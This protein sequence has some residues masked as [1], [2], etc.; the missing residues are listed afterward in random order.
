MPT[1]LLTC[2]EF[3]PNPVL[4]HPRTAPRICS[5]D[6]YQLPEVDLCRFSGMLIP[7][8][9]DQRFLLSAMEF[10]EVFLGHG[11]SLGICGHMAHPFLP[12]LSPFVP[13]EVASHRDYAV[14]RVEE[15]PVF[16]GVD[17]MDLTFRKGVAGFYGRG[18]NPPPPGARILH[19]LGSKDGPPVDYVYERPGGGRVLMHSGNDFWNYVEDA[20]SAARM[21]PQLLDWFDKTSSAMVSTCHG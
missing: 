4:I 1:L 7:S 18:H 17:T 19:R 20:S 9:S 8:H 5:L 15:H 12:E 16:E 6:I 14:Y 2:G 21:A 10:L 11:G 13:M 3:P